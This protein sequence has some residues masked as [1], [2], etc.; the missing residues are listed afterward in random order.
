MQ[1]RVLIIIA[2]E[3]AGEGGGQRWSGNRPAEDPAA[4][5]QSGRFAGRRA[6][7]HY[8]MSIPGGMPGTGS[9][10]RTSALYRN[11]KRASSNRGR[12]LQV[13]VKLKSPAL[14]TDV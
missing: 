14:S 10:A 3:R 13:A 8:P 9:F 4:G 6:G 12:G 7:P 5:S 1:P 11:G 2:K